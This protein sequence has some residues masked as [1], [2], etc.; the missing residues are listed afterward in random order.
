MKKIG[1][2]VIMLMVMICAFGLFSMGCSVSGNEVVATLDG[3]DVKMD[4]V[5]LYLRINQASTES[6]Y[7]SMLGGSL[8]TM[9]LYGNGYTFEATTKSQLMEDLQ[10]KLLSERYA[11]DYGVELTDVEI[12]NIDEATAAFLAANDKETLSD[13]T[14]TESSV[15]R[16]LTL[17]TYEYRVYDAIINTVDAE[18]DENEIAQTTINYVLVSTADTTDADGNTVAKTEEDLTTLRQQADDILALAQESGDLESAALEIDETLTMTTSSFGADDTT[19]IDELKTEIMALADGEFG[20]VVVGESGYY[21]VQL[22]AAFDEEATETERQNVISERKSEAYS[23]IVETWLEES[24]FEINSRRFSKI[25]FTTHS[26]VNYVEETET[27]ESATEETAA[28]E[29][30][31]EEISSETTQT[32]S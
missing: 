17:M 3:E 19:V 22:V 31:T 14:A 5:N 29:T 23:A 9:D 28:D 24:E 1:K 6:S 13:L 2:K 27:E 18:V 26:F 32:E 25:R 4:I 15:S 21:V 20:Q 11:P 16:L 8:W 12:A 30:T 7:G 10:V